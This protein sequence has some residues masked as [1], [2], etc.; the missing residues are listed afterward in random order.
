MTIK[1]NKTGKRA[2]K[3]IKNDYDLVV[4]GGGLSGV[5]C[6][7]SA[8]R[9]GIR[10]ALV[11]DRPVL[12]GNAS[13]EIR[14]WALGATSH[15][16][17]N[18]RWA[19]EGGV[20]DE[21]MVEN[22]HR[23]KEGNPLLFDMLL[24]EKVLSEKNIKLFLN[25]FIYD[26]E[27]DNE[28]NIKSLIA[29][30][31]QNETKYFFNALY[32][33]DATGDGIVGYLSGAS[34]RIGAEEKTEYNEGFSPS[35]KY[36]NLL[37][38]TIFLYPK[39]TDHPIKYVPSKF[40]IQDMT[41]IP[42]LHQIT[43]TQSGCN[44]WWFEYGGDKDTIYD[45]EEIKMELWKIVYGAWNYIKNS[46][47][48][49]EAENMTLEWVGMIPG[50]RESRRFN[51]L[52]TLTQGD[53][54]NQTVFDDAVSYG[55]W[56]IDL[57][58]S[59]GIYATGPSCNQYHSKGIYSIPY[60][61]FVS[62][63][64]NNL[65]FAGRLIS[66]S[67]VA[68][69][70]TRVMIT[71]AHGG[72]AVGTAAALCAKKKCMPKDILSGGLIKELQY[73]LSY[74]G[75]SIPHVA[76]D[77]KRNLLSKA[78][79]T[80][81]STF[82]VYGF[83]FDGIWRK[84]DNAI[85]QLLPLKANTEY[86]VSVKVRA[87]EDT[88]ITV[89]WLI[90]SKTFNYTP[91]KMLD[92]EMFHLR[93]GLQQLDIKLKNFP[94]KNQYVFLIFRRNEKVAILTSQERMTGLLS[95]FN[96]F[97]KAVNNYGKQT[98]PEGS[99]FESFEFFTPERRPYGHNIAMTLTPTINCYESDNLKNGFVRP[100]IL[101]N[102]WAAIPE[103]EFPELD[104]TFEKTEEIHQIRIFFDTDYDYP[105]ETVQWNHAESDMPFCVADYTIFDEN[106]KE[107]AVMKDNYQ[108]I[109]TFSFENSIKTKRLKFIFKRKIRTVPVSVFQIEVK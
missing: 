101:P 2:N 30:N 90:S 8:A 12:G 51:G 103:D 107:V 82:D 59:E 26:V 27:M 76:I 98:P 65:F 109:N 5:C 11:Q 34:F 105:M 14:V 79:I 55:G 58:P 93:K 18:N 28:E 15:M 57:H 16:G 53:I 56:A 78:T 104:V 4:A 13:S 41:V 73:I 44:Y 69:G 102:A 9:N 31:T 49:P 80:A 74:N 81:S 89:E 17:N 86:T 60:R 23:N 45:S 35:K 61:C 33:C 43:P 22:T 10:V 63:D 67:H 97:N 19:R 32:F 92:S 84:L 50:K 71:C 21:I 85:G 37:G 6:A 66:V 99:G 106:N 20:I 52:Y 68:H 87:D 77:E 95:V 7:I 72:Q 108:T 75:Q 1:E 3:I 47:K 36:G 83:P 54:I 94:E 38:H 39:M 25:T 62:K 46:G 100:Y 48:F 91:D 42:K 88:D 96:K 40:A 64:I 70:S 24:I 29:F